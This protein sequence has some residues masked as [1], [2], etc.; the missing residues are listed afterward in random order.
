MSASKREAVLL[1][2]PRE[3][4][5]KVALH[6]WSRRMDGGRVDSV[7][8]AVRGLRWQLVP[9]GGGGKGCRSEE[10]RREEGGRGSK[11]TAFALMAAK[12]IACGVDECCTASPRIRSKKTLASLGAHRR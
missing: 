11:L 5:A 9:G 12:S 7:S 3:A 1:L 2:L 4:C 6:L 10:E 8:V